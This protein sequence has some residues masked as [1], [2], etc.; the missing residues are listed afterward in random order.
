[1]ATTGRCWVFGVYA[2][3][4]N[5]GPNGFPN[6]SKCLAKTPVMSPSGPS[7]ATTNWPASFM[8]T[9]GSAWWPVVVLLTRN[10]GPR[11]LPAGSKRCA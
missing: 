10:S 4:G 11:A 3:T 1:M 9:D 2:F 7:H 8:A 6:E 5:S